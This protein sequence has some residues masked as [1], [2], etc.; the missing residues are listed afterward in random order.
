[1]YVALAIIV[2]LAAIGCSAWQSLRRRQRWAGNTALWIGVG[3]LGLWMAHIALRAMDVTW[4]TQSIQE[5]RWFRADA[6]GEL[7][8]VVTLEARVVVRRDTGLLSAT[9][10]EERIVA[11]DATARDVRAKGTELRVQEPAGGH[12]P[13]ATD[14]PAGEV[15]HVLAEW[16]SAV[17]QSNGAPPSWGTAVRQNVLP[18]PA[19]NALFLWGDPPAE[20]MVLC[21][22]TS[23]GVIAMWLVS[24]RAVR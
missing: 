11:L 16:T 23:A 10:G 24:R 4:M 8:N 6:P 12:Q 13:G 14:A 18:V 22:V 19:A 15:A 7:A 1:M 21:G 3:V 2:L 9:R 20:G 5:E 17:K